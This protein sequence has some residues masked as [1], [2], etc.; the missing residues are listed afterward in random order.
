MTGPWS[1]DFDGKDYKIFGLDG[2]AFGYFYI[3][4]GDNNYSISMTIYDYHPKLSL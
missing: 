1:L 2:R 3:R 4:N